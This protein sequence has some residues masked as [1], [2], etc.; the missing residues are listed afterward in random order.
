LLRPT[1]EKFHWSRRGIATN[2]I[3]AATNRIFVVTNRIFAA[4]NAILA[5]QVGRATAINNDKKNRDNMENEEFK[6]REMTKRELAQMYLPGLSHKAAVRQLIN[7]IK[8]NPEL[9]R[10]L[11]V[12]NY[13]KNCRLLTPIQVE[14]IVMYLGVP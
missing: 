5:V 2:R 4:T 6:P 7:W 11:S 12:T 10:E 8:R 9:Q 13:R 3:F 1:E 14:L